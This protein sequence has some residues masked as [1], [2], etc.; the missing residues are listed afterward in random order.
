ML[1][2]FSKSI[3]R[4][5][6]LM[7]LLVLSS[8]Y[9]D[10]KTITD[11]LNISERT[12]HADL[13]EITESDI[14][15]MLDIEISA[16]KYK[17]HLK[18]NISVDAFGHYLMKQNDC[19]SILEHVFFY[20]NHSVED[21]TD[22][23]H[24]SSPTIYRIISKINKGLKNSYNL[25]FQTNP[26]RIIG[27]EVEIRSFYIQYFTE[28][29]PASEWPFSD[30]NKE[31]LLNLFK[32]FTGE[33]GFKL[34]YSDLKMLEL[35]LA[36]SHT[37][38]NQ[39]FYLDAPG[40]RL[41]EILSYIHS[42]EHFY[43]MFLSVF[44]NNPNS[45]VFDDNMTYLIKEHFFFNYEELAKSAK[46][47]NYSKRSFNYLN[48][49]LHEISQQYNVPLNN[50]NDLIYNLHNSAELGIRNINVRPILINNKQILL[51]QFKDL[52]PRFYK[53]MEH[54]LTAYLDF[55]EIRSRDVLVNNLLHNM[56]TRWEDLYNN[57]Y[58]AQ[59]KIQ[60][61]IVS[62]HDIYHAKLIAS[63][64]K[65]EFYKQVEVSLIDTYDLE[66]LL[67]NKD[68]IDILVTNF[69]LLNDSKRIVAVN[70]IPTADDFRMINNVIKEIRMT[71]N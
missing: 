51:Q 26:C 53:T 16:D 67:R 45:K 8:D 33:L 61:R 35:S 24:F 56:I 18:D 43:N 46:T 68:D 59:R 19:F 3:Q 10:V 38:C 21:L 11:S 50:Q 55:M 54:K 60:I 17:I 47:D 28:R 70:D 37:R 7:R 13:K 1:E 9:I 23:H 22:F 41:Q 44:N 32:Q 4:K 36:V 12:I 25:K 40:P 6:N 20:P 66:N 15:K 63:L 48:N 49:M 27:D 57:L 39:G 2:Y 58:D 52:F 14:G 42:K 62:S 5:F 31:S 65:T 71:E 29:Y 69:T 64:L 34:Q 30:I